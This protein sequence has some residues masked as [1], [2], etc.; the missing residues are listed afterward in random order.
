MPELPEV[1]T[2]RRGLAP[3]L[4]GATITAVELRRADLRVPFPCRF[5][6]RL[7]GAQI[8]TLKRRGKFLVGAL[9]SGDS[10]IMHLGMTGRLTLVGGRERRAGDFYFSGAPDPAHD[11]VA[12]DLIRNGRRYRLLY[13][14][15]R[16][17]GLMDLA[18]SDRLD[19]SRHFIGMG[20]EPLGP[21]FTVEVLEEALGRKSAPIKAA[22]LDQRVVAGLGNIYACEALHIA[23]VSPRRKASKIGSRVGA[24]HQAIVGVLEAGIA[25]GG[26]T[27][28]DFAGADGRTGA[29]QKGFRVYDREGAPC[30]ACT[31]PVRRI[32]Q[33]G[34]STFYCSK[35]QR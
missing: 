6:E 30:P 33:A 31:R 9:S 15:A 19:G 10:L 13:N 27:L 7:A 34:R 3:V 12:F 24:L 21:E 22:L 35:C 17:F 5:A 25:A 11:H 32:I 18:P 26:S 23:G 8:I 1:E 29:F 2:V 14:D 20:P 28:R 16:R 4:E